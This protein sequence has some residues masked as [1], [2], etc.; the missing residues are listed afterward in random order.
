MGYL[1]KKIN[2]QI[3]VYPFLVIILL[4]IAFYGAFVTHG[5][6]E[7]KLN[8]WFLVIFIPIILIDCF[9]TVLEC[10]ATTT[11]H[12]NSSEDQDLKKITVILPTKDG[13]STLDA[14]LVDLLK[15]FKPKQ[16]V[17]ASNG[18]TDNTCEIARKYKVKLLNIERINL[19]L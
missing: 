9:K 13:G 2:E 3:L 10:W 14:T 6:A 12:N 4:Y 18:S 16:I 8:L 7:S 15:K 11:F 1:S 5:F 19:L 17:V